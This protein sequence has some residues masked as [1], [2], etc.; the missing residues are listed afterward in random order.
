MS[1]IKLTCEFQNT[2]IPNLFIDQYMT[3]ANPVFSLVYI[4]GLRRCMEGDGGLSTAEIGA[5]LNILETDVVNAWKHW[6]R[7]G[8]I[9][10]RFREKDGGPGDCTGDLCVSFLPVR[11]KSGKPA[12]TAPAPAKRGQPA[13]A[14]T[15]ILSTRPQYTVKELETYQQQSA[16]IAELFAYAQDALGKYLA[17][18]DLNVIFGLYEWLRLPLDVIRFLF[19]YCADHDRRDLRYIEKVAI[20]WAENDVR[21]LEKAEEYVQT[22]AGDYRKIMQALGA[23]G[24][25]PSVS[26]R[27]YMDKWLLEYEMPMDVIL[28]ACDK[29]AVQLGKPKITYVNTILQDWNKQGIRT[30]DGVRADAASF[31][32]KKEAAK[33]TETSASSPL[34]ANSKAKPRQN[35]FVNFKQREID[36]DMME[37]L[38]SEYLKRSVEG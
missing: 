26:Q 34:S 38:E 8:L 11:C 32:M 2:P 4:Y 24:V 12:E 18:H 30:V 14:K 5:E 10:L 6:E 1:N 7:E 13:P 29:T 16:E 19:S 28:E 25:F 9:D 20:D 22:C 17:Y 15:F 33:K 3:K 36:Y 31:A 37:K 21:T 27:R 23:G 35:R